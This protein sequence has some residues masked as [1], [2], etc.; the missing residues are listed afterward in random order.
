MTISACKSRATYPTR[1]TQHKPSLRSGC[2][3]GTVAA[4]DYVLITSWN[5]WHEGS[6]VEPSV[7]YR[8]RALDDTATFSQQFLAGHR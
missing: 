3:D 7:E 4:P 2:A 8:S 5:E 1:V 6:E